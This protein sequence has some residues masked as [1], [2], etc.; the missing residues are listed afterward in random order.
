MDAASRAATT[1]YNA[2]RGTPGGVLA[3]ASLAV[4]KQKL[5]EFARRNRIRRL[6]LFGSVLREDFRPDSD[7]DV[8]VEFEPDARIGLLGMAALEMELS[9]LLGRKVDLRTPQELSRYFRED[10]LREAEVQYAA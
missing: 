4:D 8:L 10:V 3:V 2:M 7:V 1:W 9:E 6:A 5:A